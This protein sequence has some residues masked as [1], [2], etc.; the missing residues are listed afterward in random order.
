MCQSNTMLSLM[1]SCTSGAPG[2]AASKVPTTCG[3]AVVVDLDQLGGIL[4]LLQRLGHHQRHRIADMAHAVEHQHRP[5]GLAA[6]AAVAVLQRH[7]AGHVAEIG[8]LDVLAGQDQQHARRLGGSRRIDLLY[9]G[10]GMRRAQHVHARRRSI[11]LGVVRITPAARQQPGILEPANRLTDTELR[12][13]FLRSGRRLERFPSEGNRS[14]FDR[15]RAASVPSGP[16]GPQGADRNQ[17]TA[18][19]T[20]RSHSRAVGIPAGGGSLSRSEAF[21]ANLWMTTP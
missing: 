3:R 18:A 13:E 2:C 8:L 21:M 9:V 7:Q 17:A 16:E 4:G 10:M 20:T 19:P 6:R 12:H 5:R 15:K 11:Q 14:R 1:W